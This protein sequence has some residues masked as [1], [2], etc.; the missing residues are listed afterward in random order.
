VNI[1][2][3]RIRPRYHIRTYSGLWVDRTR[4]PQGTVYRAAVGLIQVTVMVDAMTEEQREAQQ[5]ALQEW[6]H[7]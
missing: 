7:G 4:Y 5:N 6:L 1:G 3:W 2:R